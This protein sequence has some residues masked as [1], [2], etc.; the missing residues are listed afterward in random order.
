[1]MRPELRAMGRH[2][3]ELVLPMQL[4]RRFRGDNVFNHCVAQEY[5]VEDFAR[6]TIFSDSEKLNETIV[7]FMLLA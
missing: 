2:L 7:Q 3:Q 1:M 5:C 6:A 4:H